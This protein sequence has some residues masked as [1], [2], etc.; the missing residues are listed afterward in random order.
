MTSTR[1]STDSRSTEVLDLYDV[2][3]PRAP[4]PTQELRI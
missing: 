4:D 3:L 1:P 2:L